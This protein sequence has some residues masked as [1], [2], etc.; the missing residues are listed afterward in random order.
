MGLVILDQC[1]IIIRGEEDFVID[2]L[3]ILER[4]KLFRLLISFLQSFSL[5]FVDVIA[6]QKFSPY[7]AV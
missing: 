7:S 4:K 2:F 3:M 1:V 6:N 5:S